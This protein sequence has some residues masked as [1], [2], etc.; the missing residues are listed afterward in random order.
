MIF[1]KAQHCFYK[2]FAVYSE[3]PTDSYNKIFIQH[4]G[5]CIFAQ[6]FA[7]AVSIRRIFFAV[8]FVRSF[9]VPAENIICA[10]KK[11]L[12]SDFSTGGGD[13]SCPKSVHRQS[14]FGFRLG[15]IDSSIS[16]AVNHGIGFFV[17][18][19]FFNAVFVGKI[20]FFSGSSD[21]FLAASLQF[22]NNIVTK[23]SGNSGNQN[24]KKIFTSNF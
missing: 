8:N 15:F 20:Y 17:Q 3:N 5:D 4:C 19:K 16:R 18:N 21:N 7:P 9:S 6:K 11:H 2:I 1:G 10:D 22:F 13:I 12:R 23:L 14:K 24:H